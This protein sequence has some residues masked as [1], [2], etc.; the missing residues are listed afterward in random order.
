MDLVRP[1]IF[2]QLAAEWRWPSPTPRHGR[3]QWVTE[4]WPFAATYEIDP[5]TKPL[6]PS[7]APPEVR[8]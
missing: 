8:Q 6:W 7:S 4:P 3:H 2:E 5:P 1:V